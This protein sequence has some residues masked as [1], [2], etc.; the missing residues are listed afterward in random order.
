MRK[1]NKTESTVEE[2][3]QKIC[4]KKKTKGDAYC[5]VDKYIDFYSELKEST[6]GKVQI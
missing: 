3:W 2:A 4:F 6:I 1:K 5:E